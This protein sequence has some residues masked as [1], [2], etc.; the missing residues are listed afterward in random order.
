MRKIFI[1]LLSFWLFLSLMGC[2]FRGTRERVL[3]LVPDGL[4]A[5]AQTHLEY[6]RPVIGNTPY[7]IERVSGPAP[8][9]A[10]MASRSHDIIIAPLTVGAR[11]IEGGSPYQC[12]AIITWGNLFLISGTSLTH[13]EEIEGR[14]LIG[15]GAGA[16]SG[17]VLDVL[18][19]NHSVTPS[20]LT[21][22]TSFQAA[23]VELVLRPDKV[24]LTAEPVLSAAMEHFESLYVLDLNALWHDEAEYPIPQACVFVSTSVETAFVESYL[25]TLADSALLALNDPARV[26]L[27]AETLGYP[28]SR[29]RMMDAL[30]RGGINLV[31]AL[32][33]R[34]AIEAF[35]QTI[36]RESDAVIETLPDDHFYYG[37]SDYDTP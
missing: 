24:I 13:L 35:L 3:I 5:L 19:R 33:A 10:A 30:P 34:E 11:L 22:A 26:A 36:L 20:S 27:Q 12:A 7:D 14:D 28:F 25:E 8:L 21:Y 29:S 9:I 37:I 4:P 6:T 15:F 1:V 23:L 32:E 31:R 16:P 18:L 17:I 2:S